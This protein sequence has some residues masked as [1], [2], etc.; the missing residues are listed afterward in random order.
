MLHARPRDWQRQQRAVRLLFVVMV[1]LTALT[2]IRRIIWFSAD[3]PTVQI[4]RESDLIKFFTAAF[5]SYAFTLVFRILLQAYRHGDPAAVE[6]LYRFVV[7]DRLDDFVKHWRD[8]PSYEGYFDLME[9]IPIDGTGCDRNRFFELLKESYLI[10]RPAVGV[11]R[12]RLC[13]FL[14]LVHKNNTHVDRFI[15]RLN[16]PEFLFILSVDAAQNGLQS[17]LMNRF[18]DNPNVLIVMPAITRCWGCI[19]IVYATWMSVM[20]VLRAGF[21]CDWFSLHSGEDAALRSYEITKQFLLRYRG[22]M[23]FYGTRES[24]ERWARDLYLTP[25]NCRESHWMLEATS[26]FR[27]VFRHWSHWNSSHIQKGP[28]WW[29]LSRKAVEAMLQYMWDH[30]TFI[31]RMTFLHV[32]DESWI[33]ILMQKV[34]LRV[35]NLCD[36]RWIRWSTAGQLHPDVLNDESILAARKGFR[37]FARKMP[38]LDGH[39][40]T[41]LDKAVKQDGDS[42]PES[43]VVNVE[44]NQC[45]IQEWADVLNRNRPRA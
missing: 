10:P 8:I 27:H 23:E 20:A 21:Q 6:S 28:Q 36:L 42:F 38:E 43:L 37:L 35:S 30:P 32:A 3:G 13:A 4:R 31:L 34:G 9:V 7:R 22:K 17:D 33:Q 12:H 40:I 29:T 16:G 1:F 18:K 26:G 45:G 44:Q 14:M 25:M 11:S 5:N 19:S 15:A 41:V 39:I 2:I 24:E